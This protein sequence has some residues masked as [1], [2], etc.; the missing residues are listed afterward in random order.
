[1][2]LR[3]ELTNSIL[4]IQSKG[5]HFFSKVC[6]LEVNLHI[7]FATDK[8]SLED[9]ISKDNKNELIEVKKKLLKEVV[10]EKPM[11]KAEHEKVAK[12]MHLRIERALIMYIQAI[13]YRSGDKL[14]MMKQL[15]S[16]LNGCLW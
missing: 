3:K 6:V 7:F 15:K 12:R 10:L 2:E 11:P 8:V 14:V 4:N 1:M 16:H 5:L 9:L 13:S